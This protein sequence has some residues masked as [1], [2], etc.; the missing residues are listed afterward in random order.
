MLQQ[1]SGLTRTVDPLG[2]SHYVE[3]LTRELKARADEHIDEVEALGGM[4]RAIE[5]GLPK[6][7]IEEAAARAQARIDSG[8]QPIIGVNEHRPEH[9]EDVPVLSIDNA[10][11]RAAQL[12]R[13]ERLKRDRDP[14]AV[15]ADLAALGSAAL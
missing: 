14:K 2:G 12:Q 1:E 6:L 13:L 8:A 11:V 3:R 5:D 15:E 10:K 4:T 7:R 9:E